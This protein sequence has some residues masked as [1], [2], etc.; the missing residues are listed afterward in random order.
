MNSMEYEANNFAGAILMP[1]EEL[2]SFM[3]KSND[4]DNVADHFNVSALAAKVRVE[5]VKRNYYAY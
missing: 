5:M 4:I 3:Q 2:I 1:K